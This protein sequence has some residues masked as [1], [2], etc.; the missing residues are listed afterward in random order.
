MTDLS[1][2]REER[3]REVRGLLEEIASLPMS[4]AWSVC[5][6]VESL[7]DSYRPAVDVFR[8]GLR[9]AAGLVQMVSANGLV[10]FAAQESWVIPELEAFL[11]REERDVFSAS[12]AL[13]A[14]QSLHSCEAA[15]AIAGVVPRIIDAPMRLSD[16]AA[17]ITYALRTLSSLGGIALNERHA[18]REA[19]NFFNKR[20]EGLWATECFWEFERFIERT[21]LD[22]EEL[23]RARPQLPLASE[24]LSMRELRQVSAP[25][26]VGFGDW[27]VAFDSYCSFDA[28]EIPEKLRPQE[29]PRDGLL[30]IARVVVLKTDAGDC[31]AVVCSDDTTLVKERVLVEDL[32]A[33]L[34]R[35][36]DLDPTATHLLVYKL[37][38]SA[39]APYGSLTVH[40]TPSAR[41]SS[42]SELFTECTQKLQRFLFS[43][44]SVPTTIAP[45]IEAMRRDQRAW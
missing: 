42:A 31:A 22:L 5:R 14:L 28:R 36:V 35:F 33:T 32:A 24:E 29:N 16:K 6:R 45:A 10:R 41:V 12:V 43:G 20:F 7:P 1:P 9:S 21:Q 27:R 19:I 44:V 2:G 25:T 38:P 37:G 13:Q 4:D 15:H 34:V 23:S 26:S 40:S 30:G 17:V 18:F 11:L 8:E 3:A 39:P